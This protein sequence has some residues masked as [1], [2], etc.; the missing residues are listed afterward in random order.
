VLQITSAEAQIAYRIMSASIHF[1]PTAVQNL[2]DVGV[3]PIPPCPFEKRPVEKLG[4]AMCDPFRPGE[5]WVPVVLLLF[6]VALLGLVSPEPLSASVGAGYWKNCLVD[7]D[8][9]RGATGS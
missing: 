8:K 7:G 9:D 3:N 2:G 5:G 1:S 4:P 6:T